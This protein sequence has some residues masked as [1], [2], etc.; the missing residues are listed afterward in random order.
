MQKVRKVEKR[1]QR[2]GPD[3]TKSLKWI[4]LQSLVKQ[5]GFKATTR[6]RKMILFSKL[7]EHMV[8]RLL[9]KASKAKPA[10][11]KGDR[12]RKRKAHVIEDESSQ[13]CK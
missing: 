8:K 10:K 6:H 2:L 5:M 12:H 11:R 1:L 13:E 9:W 7:E 4:E 3:Q